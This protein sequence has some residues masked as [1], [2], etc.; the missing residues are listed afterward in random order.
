MVN[1]IIA[2]DSI[3]PFNLDRLGAAPS[4]RIKADALMFARIASLQAGIWTGLAIGL[5]IMVH[6]RGG[7]VPGNLGSS[8]FVESW[9]WVMST[10]QSH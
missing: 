1:F 6:F 8:S 5:G 2:V 7:G 9:P 10:T 3:S 4:P